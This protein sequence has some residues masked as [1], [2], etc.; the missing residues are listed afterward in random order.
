M[1]T[2]TMPSSSNAVKR[3]EGPALKKQRTNSV[4]KLVPEGQRIFKDFVIF[5]F[6][7]ND[8]SPARR[9]RIQRARE[10]GAQWATEWIDS[11]THVVMDKDL[12]WSDLAKFLGL[13]YLPEHMV[14]VNE[15]YPS[16]CIRFRS[17]L[18]PE[19]KRFLVDGVKAQDVSTE[20]PSKPSEP[21][22]SSSLVLKPSRRSLLKTPEPSPSL[23]SG[24]ADGQAPAKHIPGSVVILGNTESRTTL[25]LDALDELLAEARATSHLPLDLLEMTDDE[26]GEYE[27]ESASSTSKDLSNLE[28]EKVAPTNEIW[29]RS[30]ACMQ[31]LNTAAKS[32]NPNKCTIEVLQQMLDYYSRSD[33]HWRT[34]AYRK[35]IG[36][37]KRHPKKVTSR[38]Q[39]LSIPGVGARLADKIEEIVLTDRLR[40]LDNAQETVEDKLLQQFRGIYGCGLAQASKWV[41]QGYRSLTDLRERASLTKN[42]LIGL[43][44]YDDFAKRIPRHEVEAHGALVRQAIQ[45]V[46]GRVQVI[47]GGSYRRGSPDSGDVDLLVTEPGSNLQQIRA[48]V[49]DTVIPKLFESGYL[50][51]GLQTSRRNGEGSKW[52][53]ASKLP[54][55]DVWRRLDLLFVPGEEFG[56]ALLYFTGNDIFNRSLRLLARKKGMCLNQR[57]LFTDVMRRGPAKVNKGRLLEGRDERRIFELLGVPWRAPEQRNC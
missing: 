34:L 46:D 18:S 14:M 50:Q 8:V 20:N 2:G 27:N 51:V 52:Q 47:I 25:N 31:K 39:A 29:A 6:P 15:I 56:A 17:V 10:Y 7:N 45:S 4:I 57:G 48:V 21:S 38:V 30:F 16:E 28:P 3:G 26:A 13:E 41:A 33:D 23:L 43:E 54:G 19:Q 35:A 36:A 55:S 22:P 24:P 1:T 42:Q 12:T 9:L 40:R 53:G 37:L 11:I 5:F 49:L 32:E 44:R